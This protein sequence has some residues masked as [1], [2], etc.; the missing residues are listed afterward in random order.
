MR[1]ALLV[2]VLACAAA[3][4][5]DC[6]PSSAGDA[7]IVLLV[8]VDTLRADHLASYGHPQVRTPHLDRL[9]REGTRFA[10][11]YSASN[12]TL[13]S[14]A[15]LFTS[16]SLVRHGVLSN[17]RVT[18]NPLP[19]LPGVLQ[20]KGY[21]AAAFVSAWHVGPSM[22]FGPMLP[23]LERFDAPTEV[24]KP[25]LAA[26]TVDDALDWLKG[27]C[28]SPTFTWIHLWDPHMPYAPPAPWNTAYYTGDPR[29]PDHTSLE[30]AEYD[31][32]LHDMGP[33]KRRLK[34]APGVLRKVKDAIG[35]NSRMAKRLVLSPA[36]L[37]ASAPD[38]ATYRRLFADL[39][40]VLSDLHRTLP[41]N[42]NIAG[43]LT[44]VRDLAYLQ[45]LYT[46]EVSYV[47]GELGRLVTTLEDWGLRDRLVLVVTS[48]HGDGHGEHAIYCNH[49]GLWQEMVHVPL[50]VWAPGRVA[51]AVRSDL[52]SGIDVAPTLLR[53]LGADVP[54]TMEGHDLLSPPASGREIV[55]ESLLDLQLGL[56]DGRWKLL[57]T[58]HDYYA[59][60]KFHRE[61]G[62]IELYDVSR[63]PDER[64]DLSAVE[65]SR[66]A[67]MTAR[68]ATW[69]TAHG[70]VPE[71]APAPRPTISPQD[72]ERLRLLGYI[73]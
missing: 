53:L 72:R 1:R 25:K 69:M 51:P 35:V 2:L 10:E 59:T 62:A 40:P 60:T 18:A 7:P 37:R 42:R 31:W 33:A 49:L 70:I 36:Q 8:T 16:T 12:A 15:S 56:F 66:V 24:K 21:R 44:G 65:P 38:D 55:M 58:V 39:Q 50:I 14:H 43:M 68:L 29:S 64:T 26:E 54:A 30:G 6:T 67:D 73:E 23:G 3:C 46:G 32:A 52:A 34:Q 13:P 27:A 9:A 71:A 17:R 41:F 28:R 5:P 63:D 48:D 47:D 22:V 20:A 45:A 11:A 4:R 57:R 19:T 61:A